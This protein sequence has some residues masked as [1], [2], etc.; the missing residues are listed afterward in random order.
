M[1]LGSIVPAATNVELALELEAVGLVVVQISLPPCWT[2]PPD[3]PTAGARRPNSKQG[4]APAGAGAASRS[5]RS[6]NVVSSSS[7]KNYAR[8]PP[9]Y[10]NWWEW[11]WAN[12]RASLPFSIILAAILGAAIRYEPSKPR[13]NPQ[14]NLLE[15]LG[16]EGDHIVRRLKHMRHRGGPDGKCSNAD[17]AALFD[18]AS[19]FDGGGGA[20]A[21]DC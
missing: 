9:E 5:K 12:P 15:S 1:Y 18:D 7:N 10:I 2:S 19:L 13:Y 21:G 4:S 11:G 3:P 20:D 8:H 17:Y 14:T 16:E 6:P